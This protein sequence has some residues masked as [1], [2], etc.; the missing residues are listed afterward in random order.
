MSNCLPEENDQDYPHRVVAGLEAYDAL[1]KAT[2]ELQVGSA[3]PVHPLDAFDLQKLTVFALESR[4]FGRKIAERV[5]SDLLAGSLHELARAMGL[6]LTRDEQA[7]RF[8]YA[9]MQSKVLRPVSD[10]AIPRP[11]D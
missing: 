10:N 6:K 4:G 1:K 5:N 7:S 3:F 11:E 9:R 8:V 2:S